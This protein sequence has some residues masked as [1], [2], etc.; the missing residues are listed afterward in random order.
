MPYREPDFCNVC[1]SKIGAR[2]QC[3]LSTLIIYMSILSL[4]LYKY[5]PSHSISIRL[6]IVCLPRPKYFILRVH[7]VRLVVRLQCLW[8]HVCKF[9]EPQKQN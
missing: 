2:P 3:L 7:S 9:T 8:C 6:R 5:P 1:G 4:Y